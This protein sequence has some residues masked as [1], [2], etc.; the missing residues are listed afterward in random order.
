M[1]PIEGVDYTRLPW[2][3]PACVA[4]PVGADDGGR[5]LPDAWP[6]DVVPAPGADGWPDKAIDWLLQEAMPPDY[7][8]HR[9]V[10]AKHPLLLAPSAYEHTARAR[11]AVRD[12]YRGAAVGLRDQIP[13]EAIGAVLDVHRAE[14]ARLT[15]LQQGIERV[16]RVLPP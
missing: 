14:L 5:R 4:P 12:G 6:P 16:G 1:A 2:D 13:P 8:K 9:D 10:L 15:E 3:P 7:R 11:D